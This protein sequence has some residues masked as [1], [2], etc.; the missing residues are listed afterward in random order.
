MRLLASIRASNLLTNA[1]YLMSSGL[2]TSVLGY[3]FWIIAA[4]LYSADIIA[5]VGVLMSIAGF[6]IALGDMGFGIASIRFLPGMGR[7]NSRKFILIVLFM[8]LVLTS[9]W[10]LLSIVLF[11]ALGKYD[12]LYSGQVLVI[13]YL[14]VSMH[15]VLYAWGSVFTGLRKNK[16]SLHQELIVN[17]GK[18]FLLVIIVQFTQSLESLI[19]GGALSMLCANLFG[20][21]KLASLLPEETLTGSEGKSPLLDIKMVA[22]AFKNFIGRFALDSHQY[23]VPI[24]V[25]GILDAAD[26]GVFY[27]CWICGIA[28]RL[29]PNACLNSLFAKLSEPKSNTRELVRSAL[30]L[31]FIIL[32]GGLLFVFIAGEYVLSLFG[33]G[34]SENAEVVILIGLAA[35]P[36][37]LNYLV[38]TL[39]RVYKR[40]WLINLIGLTLLFSISVLVPYFGR[41][42]GM[43]GIA[44][45]YFVAQVISLTLVLLAL[46]SANY[47]EMHL[48]QVL[49]IW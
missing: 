22:Y 29:V 43:Y 38:V 27:V 13:F 34:Y 8:N 23:L 24:I 9:L 16:L 6:L 47:K 4:R 46:K 31:N 33:G 44:L 3:I 41:I 32:S 10:Y 1:L 17:V 5:Q 48:S 49:K 40:V 2:A 21:V 30:K 11:T 35:V 20:F 7:K 19:L 28:F 15:G 42:Y 37:S 39:A 18:L 14:F 45:A 26:A 12:F 36:W 25:Y